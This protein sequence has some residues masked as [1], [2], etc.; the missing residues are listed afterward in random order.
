MASSRHP[1]PTARTTKIL[2]PGENNC[3]AQPVPTEDRH[4]ERSCRRWQ[5]F[6]V[7]S[8][9][10][11]APCDEHVS[12]APRGDR[13]IHAHLHRGFHEATHSQAAPDKR[14]LTIPYGLC[15][16]GDQIRT[17]SVH[18][19]ITRLDRDGDD[20][21]HARDAVARRDAGYS[22]ASLAAHGGRTSSADRSDDRYGRFQC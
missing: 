5:Y 16:H 22:R 3:A 21:G 15:S 19:L 14:R 20:R 10:C 13:S 8:N 18:R 12:I 1:V 2:P 17:W 6:H 4:V 9:G 7:S 11:R